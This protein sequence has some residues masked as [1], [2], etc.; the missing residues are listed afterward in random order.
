MVASKRKSR[1]PITGS[2]N[3]HPQNPFYK[4]IDTTIKPNEIIF[5]N[6]TPHHPILLSRTRFV[7]RGGGL[8]GFR[9]IFSFL[10]L[11]QHIRRRLLHT[12]EFILQRPHSTSTPLHC[13]K[14]ISYEKEISAKMNFRCVPNLCTHK[15]NVGV[16]YIP[17]LMN[18]AK[19]HTEKFHHKLQ[20]S[21]KMQR[22]YLP[23]AQWVG[24]AK[25]AL[26][27]VQA[28]THRVPWLN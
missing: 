3:Y 27:Q 11:L 17:Y 19:S 20:S 18:F 16:V 10:S 7:S 28:R 8:I 23:K 9:V 2:S 1:T 12:D 15:A 24:R 26:S 22:S 4:D 5:R 6:A 25:L 21:V 13:D 14:I